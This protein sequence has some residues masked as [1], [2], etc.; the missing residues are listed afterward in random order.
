MGDELPSSTHSHTNLFFGAWEELDPLLEEE[1][2]NSGES[3][4]LIEEG[5]SVQGQ[6]APG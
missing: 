2:L 1:E 4:E 5:Q 6:Q 3:P